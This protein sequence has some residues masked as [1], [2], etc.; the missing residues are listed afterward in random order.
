MEGRMKWDSWCLVSAENERNSS[1]DWLMD[2]LTE[3]VDGGVDVFQ[4]GES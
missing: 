3:M 1:W 4:P 2:S